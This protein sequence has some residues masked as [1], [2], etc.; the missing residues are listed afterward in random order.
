MIINFSKII[1]S[2]L[3]LI[4]IITNLLFVIMDED[5]TSGIFKSFLKYKW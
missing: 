5:V 3:I 4:S 2:K 1:K